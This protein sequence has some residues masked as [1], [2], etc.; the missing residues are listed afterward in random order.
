MQIKLFIDEDMMSRSLIKG[1]RA[2]GIDVISVLD[3]QRIGFD[4][5]SQ[6]KYSTQLNRVLCTSNIRDFY[7]LHVEYIEQ[8]RKHAGIIF[9]PQKRFSVGEQIKRL[10]VLIATKSPDQMQSN[11]EFLSA[12]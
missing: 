4:D 3:E 10:L 6:L 11:V 2:R 8:D 12:W 7:Q 9:V 5:A 1:L